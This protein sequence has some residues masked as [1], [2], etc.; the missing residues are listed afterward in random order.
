MHADVRVHLIYFIVYTTCGVGGSQICIQ[1]V[2]TEIHARSIRIS[3]KKGGP[4][5]CR[6]SAELQSLYVVHL[7]FVHLK[8]RM[9]YTYAITKPWRHPL[10]ESIDGLHQGP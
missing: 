8:S 3:S 7:H 9:V 5:G 6:C 4:N 1:S 10:E 2:S